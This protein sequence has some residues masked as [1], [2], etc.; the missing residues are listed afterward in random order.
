M[1]GDVADVAVLGFDFRG[2]V[3]KFGFGGGF[4]VGVFFVGGGFVLGGGFGFGVGGDAG[5]V[6]VSDKDS[7]FGQCERLNFA[8]LADWI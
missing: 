8:L 2:G 6:V 7:D 4:C 1:E 3:E 5:V